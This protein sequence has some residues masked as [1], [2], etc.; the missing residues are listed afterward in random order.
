MKL[1]CDL[2]KLSIQFGQ[3]TV[4]SL[5]KTHALV[6][7]NQ[8][9]TEAS[10]QLSKVNLAID[11]ERIIYDASFKGKYQYLQSMTIELEVLHLGYE[12]KLHKTISKIIT[13][14]S[15]YQILIYQLRS[16]NRKKI[17]PIEED[18]TRLKGIRAQSNRTDNLNKFLLQRKF[19]IETT[20]I[21]GQILGYHNK[22]SYVKLDIEKY[23]N[24]S[25]HRIL[26]QLRGIILLSMI[27]LPL[28][29]LKYYPE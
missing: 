20:N 17:V 28:I 19:S 25:E 22:I 2:G 23:R 3:E 13:I 27:E 15:Q 14:A 12:I 5:E 11:D 26:T 7:Y 29:N 4:L 10:V 16:K 21:G 6:D 9:N 18:Q 8:F 1:N 24:E